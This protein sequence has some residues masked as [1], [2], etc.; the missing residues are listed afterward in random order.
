M[1]SEHNIIGV[2]ATARARARARKTFFQKKLL[3]GN[4]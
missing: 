2:R 3:L 4:T 1:S